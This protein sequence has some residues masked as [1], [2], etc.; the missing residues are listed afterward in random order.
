[1]CLL[2]HVLVFIRQYSAFLSN[3]NGYDLFISSPTDF[4]KRNQFSNICSNIKKA[5]LE[6]NGQNEKHYSR[7]VYY[8]TPY[9]QYKTNML[10]QQQHA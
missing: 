5:S 9:T 8:T 7:N 1:M 4:A 6:T 2:V 3:F 10:I